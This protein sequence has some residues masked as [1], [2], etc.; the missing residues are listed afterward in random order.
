MSS[1]AQ[2]IPAGLDLDLLLLGILALGWWSEEDIHEDPFRWE[3]E[4]QL[5][6]AVLGIA[7]DA[8]LVLG[9]LRSG[10]APEKQAALARILEERLVDEGDT[11][12]L[13]AAL[14]DPT[15]ASR[16]GGR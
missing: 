8:R 7:R 9:L 5:D 13:V 14:I 3:R 1:A 10:S 16:G 15:H 12:R 11:E 4:E 6:Q 2:I